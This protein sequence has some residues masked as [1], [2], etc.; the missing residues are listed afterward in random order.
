[1]AAI[2][3]RGIETPVIAVST[4]VRV[5]SLVP[6]GPAAKA[7]LRQGDVVIAAN[8]RPIR[9]NEDWQRLVAT[10]PAGDTINL[11][12]ERAGT[13]VTLPLIL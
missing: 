1:M 3:H 7:D 5:E 13:K 9:S 6:Q 11:V 2:D 12:V 8:D 10:T 4:G